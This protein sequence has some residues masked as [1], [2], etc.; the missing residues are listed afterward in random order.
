MVCNIV[1]E[2]NYRNCTFAL[3]PERRSQGKNI[4]G[5]ILMVLLTCVVFVLFTRTLSFVFSSP[6][7]L[8]MSHSWFYVY[9]L[10]YC[11]GCWMINLCQ[12]LGRWGSLW[13]AFRT[14]WTTTDEPQPT[15]ILAQGNLHCKFSGVNWLTA[16]FSVYFYINK[17]E[18]IRTM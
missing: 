2:D 9:S 12:R 4:F 11:S 18:L 13:M 1:N 3:L 14:L 6:D 15:L 10:L 17:L 5:N 8:V 7:S 16:V